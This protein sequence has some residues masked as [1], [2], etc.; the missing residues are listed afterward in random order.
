MK[1]QL[2]EGALRV[3][4]FVVLMI[5][6]VPFTS[7]AS[8]NGKTQA[9]AANWAYFRGKEGWCQDVDG[10]YGCQCVDL[11][12]AYYKWLAGYAVDGNACDY[13]W[14]KL[15]DGWRRI[16]GSPQA[17][18]IVVWG[19]GVAMDASTIADKNFGH[20]GIIWRV[21]ARGT[22]GTIET[23][24]EKGVQA[25][26]YERKITNVLCFIRPDF[27]I[28]NAAVKKHTHNW[29][30]ATCKKAKT[31]VLCGKSSGSALGH[32]Y[33]YTVEKK[34]TVSANGRGIKCCTR[35]GCTVKST[36]V[37]YAASSQKLSAA[38]YLYNGSV[39][40]PSVTVKDSKGKALVNGTD[41]SVTYASGRTRIGRYKVRIT[42]KG[43]YKGTKNLYF[44]IV[45]AAV[46][47]AKAA[48]YGD[49]NVKFS[50]SKVTGATGYRVYYK[51]AKEKKYTFLASTTKTYY[52]KV[53]L[54]AGKRYYF[55]VI[56]YYS[57]SGSA[58]KYWLAAAEKTANI[59]I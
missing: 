22:I 31:C 59:I 56:P 53:N 35:S 7:M 3:I 54:T 10:Q 9:D 40:K 43:K 26:Y 37:I 24:A 15:P 47:S 1:Q 2:P 46:K 57:L 38:A 8:T 58:S 14:N 11:I 33:S 12:Q 16:Y 32:K 5:F 19:A 30:A 52:K 28:A 29:K 55:K 45:P 44:T 36:S 27:M 49:R 39:R 6:F 13:A 23:R 17:G 25:S 42:F 41:Y 21:H 48:S 20:I 51:K 34:A 50:W 18:D 4:L